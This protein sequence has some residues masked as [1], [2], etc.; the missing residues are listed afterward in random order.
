MPLS[1]KEQVADVGRG[2][3]CWGNLGPTPVVSRRHS[4]GAALTTDRYDVTPL[5]SSNTDDRGERSFTTF[6]GTPMTGHI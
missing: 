6:D 1:Q 3:T 5:S 4:R 2:R